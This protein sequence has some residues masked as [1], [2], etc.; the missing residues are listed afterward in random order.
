MTLRTG[1][2][3]IISA[4]WQFLS[5]EIFRRQEQLQTLLSRNKTLANEKKRLAQPKAEGRLIQPCKPKTKGQKIMD[6][7]MPKRTT[8]VALKTWLKWT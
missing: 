6:F 4:V 5:F 1:I 8:V 2:G 7:L 3:D